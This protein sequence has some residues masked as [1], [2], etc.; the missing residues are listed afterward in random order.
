[1]INNTITLEQRNKALDLL[2]PHLEKFNLKS[3][4][5]VT[6]DGCTMR[7]A[8]LGHAQLWRLESVREQ[9]KQHGMLMLYM[10]TPDSANSI[11]LHICFLSD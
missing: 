5:L 4:T 6:E 1:M 3:I 8:K 7:I 2:Q 9:L 10:V 11:R